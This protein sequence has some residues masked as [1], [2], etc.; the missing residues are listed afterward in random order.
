MGAQEQAVCLTQL[1]GNGDRNSRVF[2]NGCQQVKAKDR[3]E[4]TPVPWALKF[5]TPKR[6][7]T[8]CVQTSMQPDVARDME[9]EAGA[10]QGPQPAH[11]GL[12]LS[13]ED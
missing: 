1:A 5:S 12:C 7:S 2:K 9:D 11:R 6:N 3:E 8:S 10:G 4:G 13:G